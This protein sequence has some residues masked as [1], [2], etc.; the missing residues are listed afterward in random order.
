M[1]SDDGTL[2][3]DSPVKHF[4]DLITK[5]MTS[6]NKPP[7]TKDTLRKRLEDAGFVDIHV[8]EYKQILGPWPKDT[9]LKQ[10]G[11]MMLLMCDTGK[12]LL[13][14]P[15]SASVLTVGNLAFH[16]Y[17]MAVFTRI[18]K[19]SPEDANDVCNK[20]FQAIRNKNFHCYTP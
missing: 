12:A 17:G 9:K 5:G 11:A 14:S 18:L 1:Y 15:Q 16:A 7:I 6:V 4:F 19:M 13:V 8:H 3:D 2:T 20:A 10:I